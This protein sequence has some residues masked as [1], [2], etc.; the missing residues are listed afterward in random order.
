MMSV[1]L[2]RSVWECF[3]GENS[4]RNRVMCRGGSGTV[5]T[6]NTAYTY[7]G[8][9]E[10]NPTTYKGNDADLRRRKPPDDLRQ[11]PDQRLPGRQP[12]G[13]ETKQ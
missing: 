4:L 9:G 10:G 6:F 12:A 1:S 3:R 11:R 5:E 7:D 8:E 2:Y 13:L